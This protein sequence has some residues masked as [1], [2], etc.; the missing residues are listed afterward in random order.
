MP[1]S[2]GS[3][4]IRISAL[5]RGDETAPFVFDLY[6]HTK[7]TQL[8]GSFET[9]LAELKVRRTHFIAKIK[10]KETKIGK[11]RLKQYEY[12]E[13]T[14]FLDYI[15]GGCEISLIIAIDFTRSNGVPTSVDSLHNLG[16]SNRRTNEYI[17][18]IKA[19]GDILQYYDSDKRIPAYGF[20]AK[21][22][23]YYD[24]VSHCFALNGNIFDP[25]V[26]GIDEVLRVYFQTLK[27]VQF[28]GPTVFSQI[29]Q[30]AT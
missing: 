3:K 1:I 10:A 30:M 22:P 26:Q 12:L 18:A 13:N 23:P 14:T 2:W 16:N 28:H 24:I 20:G 8:I 29:I 17:T 19:V 5:C 6:R 25:E 11:V 27:Q 4:Q 7:T 21:L 9:T 15:Y